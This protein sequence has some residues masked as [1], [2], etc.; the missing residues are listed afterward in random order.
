MRF[1]LIYSMINTFDFV[2][3]A[4][5]TGLSSKLWLKSTFCLADNIHTSEQQVKSC[6]KGI[7]ILTV[8]GCGDRCACRQSLWSYMISFVM[9][10]GLLMFLSIGK[11][12]SPVKNRFGI[13]LFLYQSDPCLFCNVK[14]VYLLNLGLRDRPKTGNGSWWYLS[15]RFD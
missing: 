11:H 7:G 15:S 3:P 6:A 9:P 4:R 12:T 1:N 8:W 5:W 2:P 10:T 13:T 14:H